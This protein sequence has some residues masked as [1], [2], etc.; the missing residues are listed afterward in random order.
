MFSFRF[1]ASGLADIYWRTV[2]GNIL[3]SSQDDWMND[4]R[5]SFSY[6]LTH[7]SPKD[8]MTSVW[9]QRGDIV[10]KRLHRMVIRLA[11]AVGDLLARPIIDMG[12]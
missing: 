10:N 3:D 2:P 7:F 6:D 12:I 8:E 5:V 9:L 4:T 11:Q 1:P